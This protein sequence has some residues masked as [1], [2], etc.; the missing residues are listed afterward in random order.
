MACGV[1]RRRDGHSSCTPVARRIKQPTRTADPDRSGIAPAPF[2]F[3]L[4]PGGVCRAAS[5]AGNAVRSYRTVS[6]LP[7]LNATRRGGLFSVA[8]SLGLPPPD[9]IRHR[10]SM[11]PGLSSPA[12]FRHWRGAAVRPTDALGMGKVR[13]RVKPCCRTSLRK[14]PYQPN[15]GGRVSMSARSVSNV[16]GSATPSTRACRKWR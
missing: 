3:G 7:R 9:V 16:E 14:R 6:P 13:P 5:V 12:T 10:L 4:A 8:L 11:E 1:T 15:G 2:L